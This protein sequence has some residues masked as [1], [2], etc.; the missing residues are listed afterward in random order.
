MLLSCCG[1]AVYRIFKE[2]SEPAKPTDKTFSDLVSLIKDYQNPKG[3][4]KLKDLEKIENRSKTFQTTWLSYVV[5]G[6]IA[7]K[8]ILW[9]KCFVTD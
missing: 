8:E 9:K 7:S 1:I 6:S 5:Y 3:N 4:P 2:V